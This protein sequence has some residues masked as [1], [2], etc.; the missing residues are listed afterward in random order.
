MNGPK[1]VG[2][3]IWMDCNTIFTM[4]DMA[5]QWGVCFYVVWIHVYQFDTYWYLVTLLASDGVAVGGARVSLSGDCPSTWSS[6]LHAEGY[7]FV[8]SLFRLLSGR[9]SGRR[10]RC[11]C[12]PKQSRWSTVAPTPSLAAQLGSALPDAQS[13]APGHAW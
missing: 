8:V 12:F 4:N 5:L 1:N 7:S 2:A 11:L 6:G 10:I 9:A 13:R 3:R